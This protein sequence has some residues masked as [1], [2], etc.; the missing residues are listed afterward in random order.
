MKKIKKKRKPSEKNLNLKAI[1]ENLPL[2]PR[3]WN[4]FTHRDKWSFNNLILLIQLGDED[5]D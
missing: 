4:S 1:L 5:W 3:G 2:P